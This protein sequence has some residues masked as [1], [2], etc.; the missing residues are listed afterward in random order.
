M[1]L[2]VNDSDHRRWRDAIEGLVDEWRDVADDDVI[3]LTAPTFRGPE[4]G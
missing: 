4:A 2:A 3:D 1:T